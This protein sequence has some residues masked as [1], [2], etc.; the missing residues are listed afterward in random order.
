MKI[1]LEIETPHSDVIHYPL[2]IRGFKDGNH[3]LTVEAPKARFWH[4]THEITGH[5]ERR[6]YINIDWP[7]YW[8]AFLTGRAK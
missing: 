5:K 2:T 3:V 8:A 6:N 1:T 7:I 4:I